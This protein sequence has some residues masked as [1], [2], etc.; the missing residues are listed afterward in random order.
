MRTTSPS[1]A[2][3]VITSEAFGFDA[4]ADHIANLIGELSTLRSEVN[5]LRTS[6]HPVTP[7]TLSDLKEDIYDIKNILL[8]MSTQLQFD[9]TQVQLP[10]TD[11]YATITSSTVASTRHQSVKSSPSGGNKNTS[12]LSHEKR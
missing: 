8:Q 6:Q 10:S 11:S 12:K 3:F 5:S 1:P 4:I 2:L 7:E 9:V